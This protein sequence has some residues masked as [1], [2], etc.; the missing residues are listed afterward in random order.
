MMHRTFGKLTLLV[1]LALLSLMPGFAPRLQAQDAPKA[2]RKVIVKVDPEYPPVLRTGHFEG[3]VRLEAVVLPNGNV[4]RVDIKGGNPML[5]EYGVQ[6][7]MRWKYS[8]AAA[9]TVEEVQFHFSS[10]QR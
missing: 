10:N 2:H 9:Q 1:T 5:A 7:V 4:S 6:A 8:P 3:Q